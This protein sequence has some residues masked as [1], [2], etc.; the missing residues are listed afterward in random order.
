MPA[1]GEHNKWI[2][3]ALCI[4][5]GYLG[6]HRFYEGKIWTGILWLCTGGL[7]GVGI[8]VDAILIV[9]KPEHY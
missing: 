1:T 4:L 5:L 8:I 6:L 9:M 7:C 3:L 2:A